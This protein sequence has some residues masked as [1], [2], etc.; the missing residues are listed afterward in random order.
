MINSC[1][2]V[3]LHALTRGP[4]GVGYLIVRT[5]SWTTHTSRRTPFNHPLTT[6]LTTPAACC[7]ARMAER[8]F[9]PSEY[10]FPGGEQASGA[11]TGRPRRQAGGGG[12]KSLGRKFEYLPLRT[13][14]TECKFDGNL[15]YLSRPPLQRYG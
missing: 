15:L 8:A 13:L 14:R 9:P 4:I 12:A 1:P 2:D 7:D 3:A 11:V 5:F 6:I 10:G